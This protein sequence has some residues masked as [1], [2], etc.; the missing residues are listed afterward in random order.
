ME[1]PRFGCNNRIL[2]VNL[3]TG[4]AVTESPG[5]TYYRRYL[6]G[7]NLIAE[8]LLREVPAGADPLGPENKLIFATGPITGAKVSGSGRSSVGAKSPLTEGYGDAEAGGFWGAELKQAGFDAIIVEGEADSPVYLWIKDGQ[9]EVRPA[10]HLWGQETLPVQEAIQQ[11]VGEHGARVAQIGRAG[12]RL[13]RLAC[14]VNDLTHFYGRCGIGAVMGSKNLRAIAV[15]GTKK[16]EVADPEGV[17]RLVRWMTENDQD[18]NAEFRDT[19][20]S[21]GVDTLHEEG[22]LP[23]RNFQKGQFE[24]HEKI[25]GQTMRDTILV[26][27]GT[28]YACVIRCKRAVQ[29]TEGPYICHPVYGGPEYE[30]VASLGSACGVDD[31]KAIAHGNELCNLYG[32]DTIETGMAIAFAMECFER[33]ILNQADA[34]GL[35][36]RFGNAASMVAMIHAIANRSGLGELLGE[37][38][39][40]AAEEIGCGAERYAM[41]VK[42][43]ELPMHEPRWKQGMGLGYAV[44]PTGADH[45]HNMHDSMFNKVN[46]TFREKAWPLGILEPLK[47]TDLSP[48]KVRLLY[49]VSNW[50]HLYNSLGMC[51]FMPYNPARITDLARAVTGWNVT[52]WDLAKTAERGIQMTRVFNVREGFGPEEDRL[53]ERFFEPFTDGPLAGVA[54]RRDEFQRALEVY[55]QMLGW[56][57]EGVPTP[58]RL[59]ELGLDWLVQ[60][61]PAS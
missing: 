2:R 58:G 32:L 42:G 3:T 25:S 21:G 35:D 20:T 39:M 61:L 6:G 13:V 47:T 41:H 31:L 30:T 7:R 27:R 29:V 59:Y 49:Y 48:A 17:K 51:Q 16:P 52:E 11:E 46:R 50:S 33:G 38:V 55:Y 53:P 18:R 44:S 57:A 5:E 28:C 60:Y 19:G 24:G 10:D 26:N 54:V 12:E 36:L 56:D 4:K 1:E 22:G 23:T 40:R 14:V 8:H 34:D 45:L 43:Q 9:V 37:G 15:R